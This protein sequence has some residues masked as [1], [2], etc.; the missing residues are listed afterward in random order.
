MI[1][2][3]TY[4]A[5]FILYR[6]LRENLILDKYLNNLINLSHYKRDNYREILIAM[7]KTY[8]IVCSEIMYRALFNYSKSSFRWSDSVEGFDYWFKLSDKW[9]KYFVKN[10]FKY[11]LPS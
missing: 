10:K 1:N 4:S 2:S 6:F 8:E 5:Y 9:D 11:N 3:R 7:V